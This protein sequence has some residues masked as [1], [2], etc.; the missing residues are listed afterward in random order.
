VSPRERLAAEQSFHDRQACARS[1][2]FA[3]APTRLCFQ[4]KEYLGHESWIRLAFEQ[5]GELRGCTA[6]DYGCG[7]AMAAVVMA[8]AGADVTAFDLARGYLREASQRAAANGVRVHFA[9]ADGERLPFGN[10]TY[11][12]VWG[13]AV[14][15]HLSLERAAPELRRILRPGG[16]AVFCEPW[17]ENLCLSWARRRLGYPR[18]HRTADE[19]PLRQPQVGVLQHFFTHV[20][21]Q[22]V[23]LCAMASRILGQGRLTAA[24]EYCDTL[25]LSRAP[26]LRRW[27]RYVVITLRP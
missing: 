11:D 12:R 22:G 4:D 20:N 24:L 9:Q 14:L 17:G 15:H 3:A 27:C 25:L 8:R 21:V 1:A 10:A 2:T 6:L 16:V 7:H 19:Q 23:Q 26:G 18:K 5:L 13:N